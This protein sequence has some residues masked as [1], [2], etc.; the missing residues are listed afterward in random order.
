MSLKSPLG[1]VRG[2]GSA[3]DGTH[4]WWAQRVTAVALVPLT[5]WFVY[6]ALSLAGSDFATA[7]AWLASPFNAIAMLLLIIA[8]FHHLHLGLQVV[9]EDYVHAEG[10]KIAVMLAIKLGVFALAIASGFAVL[11]VAFTA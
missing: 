11:K 3:K 7:S 6:A 5:L 2:L 9:V 10:T 8:T 1:K 4:H